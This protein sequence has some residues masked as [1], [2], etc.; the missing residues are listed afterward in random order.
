MGDAQVVAQW[1]EDPVLK[2][3]AEED[4]SCSQREGDEEVVE[5]GR[6]GTRLEV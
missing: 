6:V 2:E 1:P 5:L 3:E 4:E